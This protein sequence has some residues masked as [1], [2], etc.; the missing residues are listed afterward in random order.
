MPGIH[1]G[2]AGGA[3]N[4]QRRNVVASKRGLNLP[5]E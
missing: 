3:L 5:A 2:I 1:P 4:C